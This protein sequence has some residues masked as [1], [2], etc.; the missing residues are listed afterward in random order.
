[1]GYDLGNWVQWTINLYVHWNI[2][3][4]GAHVGYYW[5]TLQC[6][7]VEGIS[8]QEKGLNEEREREREREREQK[9]YICI[10]YL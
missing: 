4:I 6:Y 2:Y 3:Y 1:M 9:I 7:V 8:F 5:A 10:P